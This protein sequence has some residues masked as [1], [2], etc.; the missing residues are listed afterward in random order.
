V[1]KRLAVGI[2][3]AGWLFIG[4]FGSSVA[5]QYPPTTMTAAPI[6][7]SASTTDASDEAPADTDS[8][9]DGFNV[10]AVLLF[11]LFLLII[12]ALIFLVAA[13]RHSD[14]ESLA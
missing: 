9:G 13:R 1:K 2:A 10:A 14:E 4:V 6:D 7:A 3:T 12:V 5:A 11:V 8:D